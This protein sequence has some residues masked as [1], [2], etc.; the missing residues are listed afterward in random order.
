MD[1]VE[2][3]WQKIK[4]NIIGAAE[5]ALGKRKCN[6]K[7]KGNATPRPNQIIL[8]GFNE[9]PAFVSLP[10]FGKKDPTLSNQVVGR[11]SSKENHSYQITFDLFLRFL[12]LMQRSVMPITIVIKMYRKESIHQKQTLNVTSLQI[13][14]VVN[15]LTDAIQVSGWASTSQN[16]L[17]RK[18]P[19]YP[20]IIM[21]K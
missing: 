6:T 19:S 20:N 18:T 4:T 16:V 21:H 1:E 2:T 10:Y 9:Y 3:A 11:R 5:K 13:E 15:N 8:P 12:K 17:P 14:K 7:A